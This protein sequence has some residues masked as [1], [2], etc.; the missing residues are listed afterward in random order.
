MDWPKEIKKLMDDRKWSMRELAQKVDMSATYI[1][2]VIGGKPA[3]PKL[4]LRILDMR[5]YDMASA[6]VLRM[7]LPKEV[8]EELVEKE[9][10]RASESVK[11]HRKTGEDCGKKAAA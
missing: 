8:A 7:L 10:E 1:G 9:K 5:G 3:S 2:D 6:A 4:K 11:N